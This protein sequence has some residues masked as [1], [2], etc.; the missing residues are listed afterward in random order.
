MT[1]EEFFKGLWIN[2]ADQRASAAVKT[3]RTLFEMSEAEV[4]V[5]KGILQD[6]L[7]ELEAEF[8]TDDANE[9]QALFEQIGEVQKQIEDSGEQLAAV[10]EICVI[11]LDKELHG[12]L[13]DLLEH[14]AKA[15]PKGALWSLKKEYLRRLGINFD[16]APMPWEDVIEI[17]LARNCIVHNNSIPD[18]D[19]RRLKKPKLLVEEKVQVLEGEGPAKT[20]VLRT[21]AV[22][23]K[24]FEHTVG[25]FSRFVRFVLS[26]VRRR[27]GIKEKE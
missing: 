27:Q 21:I 1:P 11:F 9:D 3:S 12:I 4:D 23:R 15:K 13:Q 19:Y 7:A 22:D 25:V 5:E 10:G 14:H 16:R 20:R 24:R 26:E 17:H 8:P 6:K 18:A 2:V